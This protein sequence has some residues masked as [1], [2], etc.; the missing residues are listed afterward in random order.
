MAEDRHLGS[1]FFDLSQNPGERP[2]LATNGSLPCL[3]RNSKLWCSLSRRFVTPIELAA[4][5][6]LPVFGRGAKMAAVSLDP[7]RDKYGMG[8][9]G[10]T[11]HISCVGVILGIALACVADL[12][13]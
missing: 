11:M 9:L 3:R 4:C 5:L 10:N 1:R 12:K 8:D 7:C 2:C 6:G 13:P